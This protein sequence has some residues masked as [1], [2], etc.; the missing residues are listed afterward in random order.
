VA[1]TGGTLN[2]LSR[3]V[4]E[5]LMIEVPCGL[6]SIRYTVRSSPLTIPDS[7]PNK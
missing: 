6:S 7:Q 5:G 1:L 3:L 2:G 4:E